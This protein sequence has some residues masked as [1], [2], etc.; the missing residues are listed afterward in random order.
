MNTFSSQRNKLIN[1]DK[2]INQISNNIDK[3][4]IKNN[5]LIYKFNQQ[6][7]IYNYHKTFHDFSFEWENF[8]TFIDP[9]YFIV[10]ELDPTA[11]GIFFKSWELEF[12]K[13][14]IRLI[15]FFNSDILFR[16]DNGE[17]QYIIDKSIYTSKQI[18]IEEITPMH[19]FIKKVKFNVTV[20]IMNL[21]PFPF[22]SLQGK[23]NCFFINPKDYT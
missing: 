22:E 18:Q 13:M 19:E 14:D 9:Y 6:L 23:L 2:S 1:L 4:Q 16:K 3:Q 7:T 21:Y 8:S 12:E 17:T 20:L 10:Y 5:N 15:P 11:I